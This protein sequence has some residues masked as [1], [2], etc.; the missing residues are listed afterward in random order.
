MLVNISKH[1][2]YFHSLMKEVRPLI[3][4]LYEEVKN[5]ESTVHQRQCVV[6]ISLNLSRMKDFGSHLDSA[7]TQKYIKTLKLLFSSRLSPSPVQHFCLVALANFAHHCESSRSAILDTD[8]IDIFQDKGFLD[9]RLNVKY[10]AVINIISNDEACIYRLIDQ[11]AQKLLVSLQDSFAKLT[12][13]ETG[14]MTSNKRKEFRKG[15]STLNL[16]EMMKS[17]AFQFLS[18][19]DTEV[20]N[21]TS[22]TAAKSMLNGIYF[23]MPM[24]K[25]VYL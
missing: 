18:G 2:V 25:C 9:E 16:K 19:D 23:L 1:I 17:G 5:D 6:Q 4:E 3:V 15:Q 20:D 13:K 12:M 7:F 14:D 11:G 24:I 8:L 22:P 10:A 21:S